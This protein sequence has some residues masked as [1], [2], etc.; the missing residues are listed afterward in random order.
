MPGAEPKLLHIEVR[1]G[2]RFIVDP[3]K[4]TA[5]PLVKSS[6]ELIADMEDR[7]AIVEGRL[8]AAEAEILRLKGLSKT[9]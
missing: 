6:R 1:D 3:L 5:R 8:A 9:P 2:Q 4:K 7:L